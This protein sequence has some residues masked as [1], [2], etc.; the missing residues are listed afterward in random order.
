MKN[1]LCCCQKYKLTEVF[2]SK[3]RQFCAILTKCVVPLEIFLKILS[4][5]FHTNP[6][7]GSRADTSAKT[8]RHTETTKAFSMFMQACLKGAEE[9]DYGKR[10]DKNS[11][12]QL[13]LIDNK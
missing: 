7:S 11:P 10:G 5:K 2:I 3:P 1:I 12:L 13:I 6:S 8:D 9:K 4:I